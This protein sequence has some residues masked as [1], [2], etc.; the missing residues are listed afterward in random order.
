MIDRLRLFLGPARLR[1][2]FLLIAGTGLASLMLNAFAG[3]DPN[4]RVIQLI[5]A[6]AAVF[7]GTAIVLGRMEAQERGRWLAILA[8]AYGLIV[9]GILVLPQFGLAFLGGA[10]GWVIAGSF[11]FRVR[12]PPGYRTAIKALRKNDYAGAVAAMDE[13]IRDD[14]DD[15]AHYRFRAELLRLWG[16]LDRAR[17]DYQKMAELR[18]DSAEAWNGL[19]EVGLQAGDYERAHEA[20]LKAAELAPGDWVALYNLGMI[21]DRL[22]DSPAVIEHL[23]RALD[24]KVPE[25]RHRL[26]I[27]LYLARACVRLGDVERAGHWQDAMARQRSGLEEWEK[28]LEHEQAATLRAVLGEDVE[29]A[30]VLLDGRLKLEQLGETG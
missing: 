6:A 18:P 17:R 7:G 23:T 16:K 21:E 11:I 3:D 29:T 28:I 20:A 19:A 2:L 13:V 4:V 5:L 1:A 24:S 15:P 10:V 22:K 9:I 25:A 30:S 26:L 27:D 12:T 8:P 14:P